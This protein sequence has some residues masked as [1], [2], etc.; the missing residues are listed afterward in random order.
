MEAHDAVV[1]RSTRRQVSAEVGRLLVVARDEVEGSQI[2]GVV[3][4][5]SPA[6]HVETAPWSAQAPGAPGALGVDCVVLVAGRPDGDVLEMVARVRL[7]RADLP[8]VVVAEGGDDGAALEAIAAGADEVVDGAGLDAG[9]LWRAVCFAV[10]R[11]RASNP[12]A[13]RGASRAAPGPVS[14][15]SAAGRGDAAEV[16]AVIDEALRE[17]VS[18]VEAVAVLSVHARGRRRRGGDGEDRLVDAVRHA[19]PGDAAVSVRSGERLMIVLRCVETADEVFAVAER[20]ARAVCD[21]EGDGCLD[22]AVTQGIAFATQPDTDHGAVLVERAE[23][24]VGIAVDRDI[25]VHLFD[26]E[27]VRMLTERLGVRRELR[28]AIGDGSLLLEFQPFVDMETGRIEGFEALTRWRRGGGR[29]MSP[30][31]IFPLARRSVVLAELTGHVVTTACRAAIEWGAVDEAPL[32]VSV[33]IGADE[34]RDAAVVDVVRTTLDETGLDPALLWLE[35]P[36]DMAFDA[37]ATTRLEQLADLGV[38]LVFDGFGAALATSA[39]LGD[40]PFEIA[41]IDR[42]L[43]SDL[44]GSATG[45]AVYSSAVTALEAAG[46]DVVATGIET[47]LQRKRAV[48]AGCR[49]GQGFGLCGPLSASDAREMA[50]GARLDIDAGRLPRHRWF[51]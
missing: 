44:S 9:A 3:R 47:E 11:R 5:A 48:A 41:K 12:K 32:F 38:R 51:G 31:A 15:G 25:P 24:A 30:D 33:N 27:S 13:G 34:L 42:R 28:T 37:Q 20:V 35:V 10:V 6:V 43:G 7:A 2:A 45:R 1:G 23:R 19:V 50:T 14:P 39:R 46:L 4:G 8:V 16:V 21:V 22:P 18:G 29:L 17:S 26:P 40:T 49:L 36:G